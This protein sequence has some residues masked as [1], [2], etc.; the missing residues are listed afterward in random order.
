VQCG[1]NRDRN[2][3]YLFVH[4]SVYNKHLLFNM[5]GVNA[6]VCVYVSRPPLIC[7]AII[8]EQFCFMG[9]IFS[10]SRFFPYQ[11]CKIYQV[12]KFGPQF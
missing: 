10:R 6:P 5:H 12:N 9:T 1:V 4:M 8:R 2:L 11:L 7:L 3:H